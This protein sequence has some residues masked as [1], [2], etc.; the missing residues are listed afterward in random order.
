MADEIKKYMSSE[1]LSYTLQKL[2][3]KLDET[4]STIE[5]VDDKTKLL[6]QGE[7]FTIF[8]NDIPLTEDEF[9]EQANTRATVQP[10]YYVFTDIQN[11]ETISTAD[12]F[13]FNIT[14]NDGST[15][16]ILD[17]TMGEVSAYQYGFI[18]TLT[19]DSIEFDIVIDY[20]EDM[21]VIYAN[22][23]K[24][25]NDAYVQCSIVKGS[26]YAVTCSNLMPNACL[27]DISFDKVI[28]LPYEISDLIEGKD[29]ALS[30]K[31][32]LHLKKNYF[33]WD[34]NRINEQLPSSPGV[35]QNYFTNNS[36]IQVTQKDSQ[37]IGFGQI[38]SAQNTMKRFD[39]YVHAGDYVIV[40]IYNA[41][42]GELLHTFDNCDYYNYVMETVNTNNADIFIAFT[43][44]DDTPSN[45]IF[46]T[47]RDLLICDY[48][49]EV[50]LKYDTA[51][52][53]DNTVEYIPTDDYHPATKK[54]VD[55][56]VPHVISEEVVL[57][58]PAS[59]VQTLINDTVID[60]PFSGTFDTSK[61]YYA[62]YD[63]KEY[64]TTNVD[65]DGL[66]FS[67]NG[68]YIEFDVGYN[69]DWDDDA[70]KTRCAIYNPNTIT[71]ATDI[72]IKI[73]EVKYLNNLYI[74]PNITGL[75]SLSSVDSSGVTGQYSIAMGEFSQATGDYSFAVGKG[76]TASGESSHAEG[77]YSTA[78]GESSHAEGDWAK[79][80]G[81]CSHA[82]GYFTIASGNCQHV[83]GKNN[84]EDTE[85][86]YAHIVGNGSSTI[87]KSN[88]HTLDWDG[89]AWFAGQVVGTN[90][91]YDT[92]KDFNLVFDYSTG[93]S[94]IWGSMIVN[95]NIPEDNIDI[96]NNRP[97]AGE[98]ITI[99]YNEQ[100]YQMPVIVNGE[101]VYVGDDWAFS[102]EASDFGVGFY[103][104]SISFYVKGESNIPTTPVTVTGAYNTVKVLDE[105]YIPY[106]AGRIVTG[107][108][109]TFIDDSTEQARE[110]AE[111]FN[112]YSV[113]IATGRF[114]HAEGQ[115]TKATGD[116]AHAEGCITTASGENSHAEGLYSEALGAYSHAEGLGGIASGTAAHAEGAYTKASGRYQHVEG[117]CNI[118]DT[119]NKYIHIAGNGEVYPLKHSNA[120]TLDWNGNGWFAGNVSVDGTP[121]NDND[122][123]TKAYVDNALNNFVTEEELD[124]MIADIYGTTE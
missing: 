12:M 33:V 48:Y 39:I 30:S 32:Y 34:A 123:T 1:N 35:V 83:Q 42:T 75:E 118:E 90:L 116:E 53:K 107:Q 69:K 18:A 66:Y 124:A 73:K 41:N 24:I 121:T 55:E 78:S 15:E 47:V 37:G 84:I 16:F 9:L 85:N 100:T 54:Y 111:I 50:F 97:K 67:S 76:V 45:T 117:T 51:L 112:D 11:A 120:Y 13:K 101:S 60:I 94:D 58:I 105:K 61:T 119:E 80:L 103:E 106:A 71:N 79:A 22:A 91:P 26:C 86:K 19:I 40:K 68:F 109:F 89:N 104:D 87:N 63:N 36:E 62:E 95:A 115:A 49:N 108:T 57:T 65:S 98:I 110:G 43:I 21:G 5:Y 44:K 59:D 17:D 31:E 38:V 20:Y 92:K 81:S 96:L 23:T 3:T 7:L 122:L 29:V 113:N 4:Y 10:T 70:T 56:A 8:E 25:E 46:N 27:K 2:K 77:L 64:K 14:V 99:S 93:Y 72:V 88:A 102:N 6:P 74:N 28:H 52:P 114:S 82:E